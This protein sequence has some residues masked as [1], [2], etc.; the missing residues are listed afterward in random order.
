MLRSDAA[1]RWVV[2]VL[3][4]TALVLLP[5]MLVLG[6]TLPATVSARHWSSA[7]IGLDVLETAGLGLTALF[8]HRRDSRVVMTASATAGLLVA[9]AWFDVATAQPKFDYVQSMVLALL[10][11]LPLA[12]ACVAVGLAAL[13][14]NARHPDGRVT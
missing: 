7:W 2:W 12:A 9:D 8:V 14:W 4:A 1:L 6:L 5:W 3:G 13:R 11:E 10:V